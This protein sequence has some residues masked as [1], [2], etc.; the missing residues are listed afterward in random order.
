M[1][2]GKTESERGQELGGG[3]SKM[4]SQNDYYSLFVQK[5]VKRQSRETEQRFQTKSYFCTVGADNAAIT[6]MFVF[7]L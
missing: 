3:K 4:F 7:M 1:S 2:H 5:S 6:E